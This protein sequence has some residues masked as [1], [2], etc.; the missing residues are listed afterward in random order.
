MRSAHSS[1]SNRPALEME[2]AKSAESIITVRRFPAIACPAIGELSLT[3]ISRGMR[4][5]SSSLS[6]ESVIERLDPQVLHHTELEGKTAMQV[7]PLN[8]SSVPRCEQH[9]DYG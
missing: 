3:S 1:E 2:P 8:G 9:L 6:E 4:R 5:S 7:G